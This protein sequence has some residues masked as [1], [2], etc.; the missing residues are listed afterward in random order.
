M[1]PV[2]KIREH[3]LMMSDVLC[4]FFDPPSPPNLILSDFSPCPY[5]MMS[6][7]DPQTPPTNFIYKYIFYI[8]NLVQYLMGKRDYILHIGV[9]LFVKK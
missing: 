3:P 8:L 9:K 4:V 5:F 1:N 6:D 7:F 2:S